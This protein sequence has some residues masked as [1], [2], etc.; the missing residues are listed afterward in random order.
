LSIAENKIPQLT[1]QQ[2]AA[3]N[4]TIQSDITGEMN[5][6]MGAGTGNTSPPFYAGGHYN[7]D[8]S[9]QQITKALGNNLG[10]TFINDFTVGFFG[11]LDGVRQKAP[12]QPGY[13]LHS[14]QAGS[15][16]DFHFDRFGYG[17]LLGH[18]GYDG[19]YGT[20]AH[21]CLDPAWQH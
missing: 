3:L 5:V 20:V 18:W 14:K 9:N 8:I 11:T 17:N 16:V 6:I 7:L 19:I 13:T 2:T 12:S 1:S 15:G 4:G 21:P 10:Q